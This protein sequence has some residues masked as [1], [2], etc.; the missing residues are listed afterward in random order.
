MAEALLP[1]I[2]N[3]RSKS[4]GDFVSTLVH[5]SEGGDCLSNDELIGELMLV[6]LAGHDTT[7]NTMALSINALSKD[8]RGPGVH[9][10]PS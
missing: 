9:P 2:E 8:P 3:R 1:E 10:C 6:L 5:A 7:L 4:T